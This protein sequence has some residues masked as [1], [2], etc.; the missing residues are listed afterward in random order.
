[1]TA[2]GWIVMT[3]SISFVVGLMI[4]CF[5]RVFTVSEGNGHIQD[6]LEIDTRDKGT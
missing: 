2:A 6:P 3:L 1:M 4:F 5:Y